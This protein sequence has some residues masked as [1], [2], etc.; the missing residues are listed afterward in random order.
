MSQPPPLVKRVTKIPFFFHPHLSPCIPLFLEPT[1]SFAPGLA[2]L[3]WVSGLP[4]GQ[5]AY[6]HR[7]IYCGFSRWLDSPEDMLESGAGDV[8]ARS[9]IGCKIRQF[10]GWRIAW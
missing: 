1:V 5:K 7:T 6:A 3:P 10:N 2:Q 4:H 9:L 8:I